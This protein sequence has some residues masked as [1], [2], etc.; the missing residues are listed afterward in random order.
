MMATFPE[1]DRLNILL[2]P[3]ESR[4]SD[5]DLSSILPLQEKKTDVCENINNIA[6]KITGAMRR[7]KPVILM[8]G[9]HVIRSGVQRYIIDLI[10]KG[11][12]TCVA[13]NGACVIHD[14]ELALIGETT[15]N[16]AR[17]IR[18][19]RFGFWKE[20]GRINEVVN[21][22]AKIG[23]GLGEA[24]GKAIYEGEFPNKEISLFSICYQTQVL[25]TTHVG[26]GYDIVHQHPN[27]DGAAYGK[28]SY[29]DFLRFAKNIENLE[30][31]VVLVFG[32]SIMAPEVFLKALSMA[33]NVASQKGKK[34]R[35]FST[36]VC[37]LHSLPDDFSVEASKDDPGYYFR[38]W[39]TL[40]IRTVADGGESF[41]VQGTHSQTIPALW[42]AVQQLQGKY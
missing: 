36:L 19:G 11:F 23:M 40:L 15:E 31:G 3:I 7:G 28:T 37:D 34:I 30:G 5:L 6:K 1:L 8:I 27:C 38:P 29:S 42:T 33:R 25:I 22:A 32:S 20:T 35:R 14:W 13:T 24:V 12:I 26:I 16:V 4:C 41:Y 2:E 18:D 9:A 17:Y 10:Q 39:K 21:A